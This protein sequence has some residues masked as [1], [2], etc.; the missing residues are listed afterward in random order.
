M[1]RVAEWP[2]M[3]IQNRMDKTGMLELGQGIQPVDNF[4][5]K[6]EMRP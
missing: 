4:L 6:K 1:S 2:D 3:H 5:L